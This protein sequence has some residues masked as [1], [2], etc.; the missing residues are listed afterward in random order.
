MQPPP[1]PPPPPPSPS[2]PL[3]K[4]LPLDQFGRK[5]PNCAIGFKKKPLRRI[6]GQLTFTKDNYICRNSLLFC[7][8]CSEN[9]ANSL[10][11]SHQSDADNSSLWKKVKQLFNQYVG[12]LSG[13]LSG[14]GNA[15]QMVISKYVTAY[16]GPAQISIGR[17]LAHIPIN[18]LIV[19]LRNESFRIAQGEVFYV[20]LKTVV[21]FLTC[22]FNYIAM[23][24]IS[25]L[26]TIVVYYGTMIILSIIISRVCFSEKFTFISGTVVLLMFSGF[27]AYGFQVGRMSD[28]LLASQV[29]I[30]AGVIIQLIIL[31]IMPTINELIGS[32]FNRDLSVKNLL[33]C[34]LIWYKW[35]FIESQSYL[36]FFWHLGPNMIRN[37]SKWDGE[38]NN[39]LHAIKP[40]L[41]EWL[42]LIVNHEKKSP[43]CVA[44]A[45]LLFF[46]FCFWV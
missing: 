38:I 10:T 46:F 26:E 12:V 43:F 45:L 44:Y 36:H 7:F 16:C 31:G 30:P 5:F 2:P 33:H 19:K 28:V 1:P 22:L 18:I 17:D 23:M 4:T 29:D 20:F 34:S 42:L 40:K 21:D 6:Y 24:Y 3:T 39:K 27:W 14:L 37:M 32:K 8:Y 15:T 41:G 25:Y 35:N 9:M 13:G 11:D